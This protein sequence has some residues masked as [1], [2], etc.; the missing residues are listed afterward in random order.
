MKWHNFEINQNFIFPEKNFSFPYLVYFQG[1]VGYIIQKY[2]E[3]QIYNIL[4]LFSRSVLS[5]SFVTPWTVARQ[6]PLS[7]GFSRKEILEWIAMPSSRGSSRCR[8]RTRVSC[9]VWQLPLPLS[10]QRHPIRYCTWMYIKILIWKH[11]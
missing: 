8:D 10:H 5:D 7:M 11:D 4:L 1:W 3:S 9:T 2:F 6:D